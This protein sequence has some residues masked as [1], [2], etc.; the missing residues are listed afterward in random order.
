MSPFVAAGLLLL[1][2]GLAACPSLRNYYGKRG[3]VITRRDLTYAASPSALRRKTV[4][5]Q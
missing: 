5:F 4:L 1:A 2:A 3:A